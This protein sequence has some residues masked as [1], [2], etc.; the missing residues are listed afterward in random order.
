MPMLKNYLNKDFNPRSREG[1]D[2]VIGSDVSKDDISIRAPARGATVFLDNLD[3]LLC[4][5]NPRSREGSDACLLLAHVII[6]T[7]SIRAPARGATWHSSYI[8][9]YPIIS[10]RAPA[11]GATK[12]SSCSPPFA[13]FQSALP[14]GERLG[15]FP[16]CIAI[17]IFQS[18]LPRGE[19]H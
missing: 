8:C 19:R 16:C 3:R 2:F 17:R 4:Y 9:M 7:I 14:R 5:F 11:R 10:I 15:S 12:L 13:R 6:F 18:A 1:S